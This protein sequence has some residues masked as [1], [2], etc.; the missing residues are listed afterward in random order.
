MNPFDAIEKLITEHGSAAILRERITQLR[1]QFALATERETGANK[2][3]EIADV[4]AK[5]L[6]AELHDARAEIQ[7]LKPAGFVESMGVL[8]KRTATGFEPYPYCKGCPAPTVMSPLLR[9]RGWVCATGDHHA[10]RSQPPSA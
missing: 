4:R 10:P 5:N 6:E 1:E 2:R 3:A 7:R 9:G 8:W